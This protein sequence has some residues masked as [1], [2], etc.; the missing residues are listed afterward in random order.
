MSSTCNRTIGQP[1]ESVEQLI[2]T[3]RVCGASY[4]TRV[5][6]ECD[7]RPHKQ[8]DPIQL[9]VPHA[10][11]VLLLSFIAYKWFIAAN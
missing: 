8:R 6:R 7:M 4:H 2:V 10:S 1:H 5:L 3:D 9:D 11:V